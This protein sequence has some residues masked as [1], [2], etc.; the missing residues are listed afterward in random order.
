MKL[1]KERKTEKVHLLLKQST[2]DILYY[3]AKKEN[4]S[5]NEFCNQLFDKLGLEEDER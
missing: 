2:K 3:A 1:A 5:V 4:L